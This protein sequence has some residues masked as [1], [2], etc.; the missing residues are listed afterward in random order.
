MNKNKVKFI[1]FIALVAVVLLLFVFKTSADGIVQTGLMDIKA[2]ITGK[3]IELNLENNKQVQKGE[4]LVQFDV[5]KYKKEFDEISQKLEDLNVQ[6]DLSS[7]EAN[8]I[9]VLVEQNREDFKLAKLRLENANEDIVI[10]KNALKDGT[11]TNQDYK[12]ALANLEV[13]K[14]QYDEL[15]SELEENETLFDELLKR[16]TSE[17]EEI[18]ALSEQF[19]QAE[20]NLSYATISSPVDGVVVNSNAKIGQ[21]VNKNDVL[22]SL[23][24]QKCYVLAEF[25]TF[26]I[27]KIKEGQKVEIF[28]EQNKFDGQVDEIV[29]VGDKTTT[30]KIIFSQDEGNKEV[31]SGMKAVVNIKL[32]WF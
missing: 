27:L 28:V 29:S 30:A 26:G 24:P 15:Q 14:A 10:Y 18:K 9:S 1:F 2:N 20:L 5:D 31:L 3:I 12:N 17:E 13:A 16:K 19:K 22:A 4:I 25:K 6:N 23:V 21:T 32:F 8:E 11:V 7:K